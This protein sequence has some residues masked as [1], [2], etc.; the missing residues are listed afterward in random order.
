M[1]QATNCG[2][3]NISATSY[4]LVAHD[5]CTPD[6]TYNNT[7]ASVSI[8]PPLVKYY[9]SKLDQSEAVLYHTLQF[10]PRREHCSYPLESQGIKII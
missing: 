4:K 10:I 9:Q 8:L 2:P 5:L 7:K 1:Q 6:L 3:T